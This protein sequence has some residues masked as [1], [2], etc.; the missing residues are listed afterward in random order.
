MPIGELALPKGPVHMPWSSPSLL[1][2]EVICW[3]WWGSSR[4]LQQEHLL[5]LVPWTSGTASRLMEECRVQAGE[6][7]LPG[8]CGAPGLIL[9]W[10]H[11]N[12]RLPGSPESSQNPG[13]TRG[14]QEVTLILKRL[15][16]RLEKR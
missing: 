9:W 13:I 15:R 6:W 16:L 5:L 12:P 2:S 1:L 7:D 3:G 11:P 8:V 14:V 4:I 10:I